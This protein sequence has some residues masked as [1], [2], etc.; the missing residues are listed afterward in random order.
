MKD[1]FDEAMYEIQE[2]ATAPHILMKPTLK[3]DG[4]M[5]CALYGED[6][7]SGVAGFGRTPQQAMREF[8]KAWKN[9]ATP[10]VRQ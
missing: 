9:S 6:L 3:P 5:W 8:D 10:G 7:M 2:S 4:D 1:R